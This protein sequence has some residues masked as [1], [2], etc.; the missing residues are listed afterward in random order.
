VFNLGIGYR[1]CHEVETLL[2]SNF[3]WEGVNL[4][5][6]GNACDVLFV[7]EMRQVVFIKQLGILKN[8]RAL[9]FP[10]LF[11]RFLIAQV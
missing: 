4:S 10:C 9:H 8:V 7:Q 3:P 2:F 1:T 11:Q 5:L 6:H